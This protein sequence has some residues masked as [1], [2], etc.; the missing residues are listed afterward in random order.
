MLL[1]MLLMLLLLLLLPQVAH[2]LSRGTLVDNY[3]NVLAII[4]RLRQVCAVLAFIRLRIFLCKCTVGL[5]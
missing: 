1:L 2:H 4:M 5:Q 3:T